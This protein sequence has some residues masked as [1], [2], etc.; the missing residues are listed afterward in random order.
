M[1]ALAS[2]AEI[3]PAHVPDK[4]IDAAQA[5]ALGFLFVVVFTFDN[6]EGA[7][8]LF[9]EDEAAHFMSESEL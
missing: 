8:E 4:P 2:G 1:C 3:L 9:E 6:C 7:V 5:V